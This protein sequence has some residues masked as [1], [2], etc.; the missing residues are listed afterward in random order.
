M[1]NYF[2]LKCETPSAL[3]SNVVY[4]FTCLR[5][6]EKFYIGK[7][8]RHLV[9]RAG[10]HFDFKKFDSR[11]AIN[12]HIGECDACSVRQLTFKDLTILKKC[13]TDFEAKIHEAFL[14]KKL[15]PSLNVQLHNSGASYLLNV[16]N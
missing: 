13:R 11:S 14:I 1:K 12:Q 6:A 3:V 4:K 10:E 8:T 7:T 2:S 9:T 5:D 16:F 15:K